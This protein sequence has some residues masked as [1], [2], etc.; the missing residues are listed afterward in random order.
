MPSEHITLTTI[1]DR[2]GW[3]LKI[4]RQRAD[5]SQR[6][7]ARRIGRHQKRIAT[8]E[9]GRCCPQIDTVVRLAEALEINPGELLRDMR[10]LAGS[11]F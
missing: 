7:L 4:A 5:I 3:N 1:P 9:R 11:S 2:F 8:W 6:E 10:G